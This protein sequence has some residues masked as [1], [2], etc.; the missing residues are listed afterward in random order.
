MLETNRAAALLRQG[1]LHTVF[2]R[3]V[4]CLIYNLQSDHIPDTEVVEKRLCSHFLH[5]TNECL[6]VLGFHDQAELFRR[7]AFVLQSLLF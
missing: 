3:K 1:A 4:C 2:S 5:L 7:K 6:Q